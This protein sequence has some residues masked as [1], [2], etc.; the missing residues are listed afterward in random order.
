[1]F[2]DFFNSDFL[3]VY[4]KSTNFVSR[5]SES[6]RSDLLRLRETERKHF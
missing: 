4:T 6:L 3:F 5:I 1:M 2:F